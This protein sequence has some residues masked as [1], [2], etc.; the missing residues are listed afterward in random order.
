MAATANQKL[1]TLYLKHLLETETDAEHG[2]TMERILA[3]LSA[4][5]IEAERKSIYTDLDQLRSFGL[6]IGVRRG[7]QTE[8]MLLNHKFQLAELKLLVDAVSASRFITHKKSL[9]LIKK[10]EGETSAHEARELQR[11]VYVSKRI[12]T[13][14]ESIYYSVDTVHSA[15]NASK[16]VR[17]KYFE[18]S[19]DKQRVMRHGGEDYEVS[20]LALIYS[21]E[22]YY[23]AAYSQPRDALVNFRVDRMLDVRV[24]DKPRDKNQQTEY[25]D[26]QSYVNTRFSMYGGSRE[27]VDILFEKSLTTVV[28]DRFGKDVIMR[29]ADENHFIVTVDVDVSP[30]FLSWVFMF[31]ERAWIMGPKKVVESMA[32]MS[33][34]VADSYPQDNEY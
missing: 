6:D 34:K 9:E 30:V 13:M 11:Q 31:G 15:I 33:R 18:Y 26:P 20:P 29:P 25:F 28:I 32:K 14:N 23:L 2:V 7:K 22:N 3:Y 19:I 24:V 17:F 27:R 4:N 5:G 1:K 8:Y 10:L 21:D 16:K 12:K